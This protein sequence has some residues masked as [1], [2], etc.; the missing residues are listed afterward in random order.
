DYVIGVWVGNAD[1]EGRPG[2]IGVRA[3]A[4]VLF[5]IAALLPAGGV[6]SEPVEEMREAVVCRKSGCRAG[7]YCEEKDTVRICAAGQ[8]TEICPYHQ[9]VYLDSTEKWRVTSECE[10]VRNMK[11]KSW[12][13]L[14]PVQE[15]YYVRSHTDYRKL[16][17]YRPGCHPL[18]EVVMEMIYP[19]RGTRVF[20]PIDFGGKTGRVVFEAVHRHPGAE[21][22][23]HID[24]RYI[25]STRHIHQMELFL[26]EG[27][28]RLTLMD[29]EGNIL[30]QAFRVVGKE[31]DAFTIKT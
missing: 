1:G 11:K 14:P 23:W 26:P 28:H 27:L 20:I 9:Y 6:F 2:L 16:P 18:G 13:V 22:Y 24:D 21:V 4:P 10:P 17:P 5:E 31:A 29:G 8:R 3:A 15:W 7:E 19:Q 25:G 30:Q 12:F